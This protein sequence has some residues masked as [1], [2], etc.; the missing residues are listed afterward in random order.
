[1]ERDQ[2]RRLKLKKKLEASPGLKEDVRKKG[3]A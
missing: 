2:L 3:T 1:M